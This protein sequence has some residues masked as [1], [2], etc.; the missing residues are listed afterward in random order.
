MKTVLI[1]GA[2]GFLGHYLTGQLL[3]KGYRVIATG[4]GANRLEYS[5]P[6]FEYVPLDFTQKEQVEK[7]VTE[8]S[9][10]Y[11]VHGGAMTR[12]DECELNKEAAFLTNV[13]GTLN[14]LNASARKPS[15]FI[16]ISTDFVFSGETGMYREEDERAPVNYYGLTKMMAE[17]EVM[18]YA[19]NWSIVRTVLVYG[20]AISSRQN[21]VTSTA[22]ALQKGEKLRIFDDQMRTPTYVED[23]AAGIVQIIERNASGI[24]HLSGKDKC[25]PYELTCKVARHLN[26]NEDLIERIEEQ[27]LVQP[28]RRPPKTGFDLSKAISELEYSC[29]SLEEGLELTFS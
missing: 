4:K 27:D 11:I 21:I 14:M 2:N 18:K 23:L 20:K 12:P 8:Y 29:H 10:D 13:T 26:L 9:P 28:A 25:S 1:T 24:Y 6:A 3:D 19:G 16:Y 7:V 15:S 17:D 5:G 22:I